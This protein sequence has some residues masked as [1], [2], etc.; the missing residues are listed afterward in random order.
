[1]RFSFW[2]R[3]QKAV[4]GLEHAVRQALLSVPRL[5]F[6][7][8]RIRVKTYGGDVVLAGTVCTDDVREL[9]LRVVSRVPGVLKVRN[10][11]RTDTELTR[12]LRNVLRSS[13]HT[14]VAS[15]E[16]NVVD[17]VAELRGAAP[18]DAQLAAIKMALAID[19]IRDVANYLQLS[20]A[21]ASAPTAESKSFTKASDIDGDAR[22][23]PKRQNG[24]EPS[25]FVQDEPLD[26]TLKETFPAS[27]PPANTV[28]TAVRPAPIPSQE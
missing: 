11:I 3:G 5:R 19:G 12:A 2:P 28:V 24:T 20:T 8:Q 7:A 15:I 27:D 16:P 22:D 14:A 21:A 1:M 25:V 23:G 4:D 6:E 17:G 10:K 26:E 18:Y 13:P 9:A